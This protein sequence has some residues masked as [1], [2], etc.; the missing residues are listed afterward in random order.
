MRTRSTAAALAAA[1]P[2]LSGEPLLTPV[3]ATAAA[4][5]DPEECGETDAEIDAFLDRA[6]AA[7]ARLARTRSRDLRDVAVKLECIFRR[8]GD[9]DERSG[10]WGRIS[11]AEGRLLQSV[12]RDVRAL[13]ARRAGRIAAP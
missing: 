12:L 1:F 7:T 6:E 8:M 2:A 5:P 10:A 4:L 3:E 9:P 11:E 13:A